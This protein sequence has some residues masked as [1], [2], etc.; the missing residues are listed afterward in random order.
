MRLESLPAQL[1]SFIVTD[2]FTL[3]Q[4]STFIMYFGIHPGLVA[5]HIQYCT[6]YKPSPSFTTMDNLEVLMKLT[7]MVLECGLKTLKKK[8]AENIELRFKPTAW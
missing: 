8:C 7:H 5:G 4:I 3:K 6:L 2:V 1:N